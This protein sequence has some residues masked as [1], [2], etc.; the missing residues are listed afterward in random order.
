M[1]L[2]NTTAGNNADGG[3]VLVV[4]EGEEGR[5]QLRSWPVLARGLE[6]IGSAGEAE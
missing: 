5:G 3:E 1:V 4:L 2:R 6:E